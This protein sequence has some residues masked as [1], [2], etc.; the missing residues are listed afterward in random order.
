MQR[1]SLKP[2]RNA[3]SMLAPA[4]GVPARINPTT[5]TSGLLRPRRERP[6]RHRSQP[7]HEIPA[8]QLDSSRSFGGKPNGIEVVWK[9]GRTRMHSESMR[10]SPGTQTSPS[11]VP[12]GAGACFGWRRLR[13]RAAACRRI[14][15]AG[16][17]SANFCR[18]HL[19]EYADGFR[20][21]SIAGR[22]GSPEESAK[23]GQQTPDPCQPP[24]LYGRRP[25]TS[26]NPGGR[27]ANR[28]AR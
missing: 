6:R 27:A 1:V 12:L 15:A 16:L 4:S 10:G 20:S 28:V 21:G 13:T 2:V 23:L 19:C 22:A 25:N 8:S 3:A 24:H 9:W 17:S 14:V 7:R 5:S 11:S 18:Q 26:K